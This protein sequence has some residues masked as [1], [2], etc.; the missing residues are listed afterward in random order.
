M[1]PAGAALHVVPGNLMKELILAL[2][3]QDNL[4]K[5]NPGYTLITVLKKSS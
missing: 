5:A 2:E 3:R 1:R 4:F